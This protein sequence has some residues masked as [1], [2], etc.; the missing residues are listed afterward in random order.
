MITLWDVASGAKTATL[1]H[2]HG[3]CAIASSPVANLLASASWGTIYFWDLDSHEASSLPVRH[4]P[5]GGQIHS[6]AFSPDGKMLASANDGEFFLWDVV[7]G[8]RRS[9][10]WEISREEKKNVPT[11]SSGNV[12]A[13][14]L[15]PDGKVLA[16]GWG[17]CICFCGGDG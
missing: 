8:T 14:A 1:R 3:S 17:D 6:L 16:S 5:L 9:R 12:N 15:S 7:E 10:A 11:F 4:T 13:V 2:P